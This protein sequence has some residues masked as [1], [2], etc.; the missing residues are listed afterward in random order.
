MGRD[1]QLLELEIVRTLRDKC[2]EQHR[3]ISLAF[4]AFP[5]LLQPQLN[6]YMNKKL[7]DEEL[8]V[9]ASH[10]P[11]DRW[12]EYL[13]ILQFCK[14][15]GVRLVACGAPLEVCWSSLVLQ[16]FLNRCIS[17]PLLLLGPID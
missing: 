8:K 1:W 7:T 2:F 5:R 14:N 15:K 11:E 9:F 17:D 13:P 6:A 4:E 16:S 12:L 3:S 10:M